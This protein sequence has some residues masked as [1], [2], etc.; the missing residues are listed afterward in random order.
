VQVLSDVD[1]TSEELDQL[2]PTLRIHPYYD[3]GER[4]TGADGIA[5]PALRIQPS[6]GLY[7]YHEGSLE[8]W[9]TSLQGAQ[10]IAENLYLLSVP[11]K[12]TAKVTV[13]VQAVEPGEE[14]MREDPIVPIDREEPCGCLCQIKRLF[15]IGKKK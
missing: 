13:K 3:T 5:R 10:R 8:G 9:Q 12:G 15:G 1:L 11:N 7:A 4:V 14:R 2:F 6:F